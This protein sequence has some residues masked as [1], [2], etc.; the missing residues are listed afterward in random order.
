[1]DLEQM[2]NVFNV[3]LRERTEFYSPNSVIICTK[4]K[5]NELYFDTQVKTLKLFIMI[6]FIYLHE[7]NR[8]EEI[9]NM[10]H[11]ETTNNIILIS[12]HQSNDT[13]THK[14]DTQKSC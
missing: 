5:K 8:I 1:M 4:Q 10:N 7:I 11:I 12:K 3:I 9:R 6:L 2:N 13:H 14:I